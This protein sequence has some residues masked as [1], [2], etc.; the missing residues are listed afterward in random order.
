M[1]QERVAVG[2]RHVLDGLSHCFSGMSFVA[3]KARRQAE[4]GCE[5]PVRAEGEEQNQAILSAHPG[6]A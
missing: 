3:E 5:Q 4:E 2:L 1:G 6:D